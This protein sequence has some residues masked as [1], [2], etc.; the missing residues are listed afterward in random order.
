ME[1]IFA[2]IKL[3]QVVSTIFYSFLGLGLFIVCFFVMEKITHFS[4]HKEIIDEHNTAVAMIISA[5]LIAMG[6]ILAAVI[7]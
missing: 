5:F 6:L 3:S 4:I 1:V 2:D 7:G